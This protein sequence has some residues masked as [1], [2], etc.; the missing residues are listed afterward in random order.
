MPSVDSKGVTIR[1]RVVGNGPPLVLV[2]GWTASGR[3]NWEIPGWFDALKP[4]YRLIVPDLRGH[5]RSE[6]PHRKSAYSLPL[7]AAD[8]LA[9]MDH[10]GVENAGLMGYSMGGM[11]A[12]EL[13]TH[14]NERFSAAVIGGM[15]AAFPID[16]RVNCQEEETNE[17]PELKRSLWRVV[18]TWAAFVRHYDAIAQ[19]AVWRG[20]FRG[21]PP[22]RD[23]T[24]L[25]KVQ[26]P[27]LIVVGTRDPLCPGTR[28]LEER[29]PNATRVTLSGRTH[30]SAVGDPR[31]KDAVLQFFAENGSA[32]H[33]KELAT[34]NS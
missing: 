6:K 27:V 13:L 28:L 26:Q 9:V 18:K 1:Y 14:H 12:L 16:R 17:P 11:T 32:L 10:A 22:V 3:T 7:L 19:N 30:I 29:L 8:V 33:S 5:G 25:S 24:L 23:L 4:H 20:V 21:R 34:A 2:H 31:F 15:G